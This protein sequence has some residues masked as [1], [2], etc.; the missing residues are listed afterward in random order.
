MR[1]EFVMALFNYH[2]FVALNGQMKHRDDISGH[3]L[4][5][6]SFTSHVWKTISG[7]ANVLRHLNNSSLVFSAFSLDRNKIMAATLIYANI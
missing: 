7:V 6:Y 1:N 4:N 2:E 3:E 5:S